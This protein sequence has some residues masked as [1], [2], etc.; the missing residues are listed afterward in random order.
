MTPQ[1]IRPDVFEKLFV[2][3]LTVHVEGKKTSLGD[4][5]EVAQMEFLCYPYEKRTMVTNSKGDEVVS[6]CCLYMRGDDLA[7]IS[8]HAK[9]SVLDYQ[10]SPVVSAEMYR[11]RSGSRVIGVLYLP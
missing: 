3:P 4:A 2:T 8:M 11:G 7:Q 6:N 5:G 10:K 9:I 1:M